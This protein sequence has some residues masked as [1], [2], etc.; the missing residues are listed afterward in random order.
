MGNVKRKQ[1]RAENGAM[2]SL[3]GLLAKYPDERSCERRLIEVRWPE[4]W[5]CPACGNDRCSPVA[6]RNRAWQCTRCSRHLSVTAGTCTRASKVPLTKWFHAIWLCARSKRG[7][8]A[9]ELAAQV[10]VSENAARRMLVGVRGA[11]A[12][13]G[14]LRRSVG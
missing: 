5:S 9:M 13:P 4:G 7:V 8:S 10:G 6:D 11:M 14:C 2:G 1:V 3:H 12:R